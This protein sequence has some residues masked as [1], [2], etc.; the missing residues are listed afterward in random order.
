VRQRRGDSSTTSANPNPLADRDIE[1]AARY[2][3]K[4][5]GVHAELRARA[6]AAE[7]VQTGESGAAAVWNEIAGGIRLLKE[8]EVSAP[9][10]TEAASER[11]QMRD[12]QL[13]LIGTSGRDIAIEVMPSLDDQEAISDARALFDEYSKLT[14]IVVRC[15]GVFIARL[16]REPEPDTE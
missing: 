5:H 16:Q 4:L 11:R 2:M 6:R 9:G 14:E 1:R 13:T 3:L 10:P 7:L 15:D 8:G 12:Y